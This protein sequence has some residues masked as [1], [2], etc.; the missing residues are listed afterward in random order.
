MKVRADFVTNSSSSSFLLGFKGHG[1]TKAQKDAIVRYVEY[2]MLGDE[3]EDDDLQYL[4]KESD[5]D[6]VNA[7]RKDG[8]AINSGSVPYDCADEYVSLLQ[9]LWCAIEQADP[10]HTKCIDISMID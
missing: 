8:W 1:L 6:E 4:V 10:E 2:H 3:A 5:E 9:G 7:L